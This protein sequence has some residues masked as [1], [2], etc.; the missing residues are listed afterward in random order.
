MIRELMKIT[1]EIT[2]NFVIFRS[3]L[4]KMI[5]NSIFL[6]FILLKTSDLH[7]VPER[8]IELCIIFENIRKINL[9]IFVIKLCR[10]PHARR[11]GLVM[12]Q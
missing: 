9:K 11:K 3:R 7:L 1:T 12:L 8:K 6:P 2:L 10:I 4:P 5:L